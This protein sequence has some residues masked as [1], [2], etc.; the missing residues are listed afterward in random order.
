[1]NKPTILLTTYWPF[2]KIKKFFHGC[3]ETSDS[4]T[5]HTGNSAFTHQVRTAEI[6]SLGH[7][8]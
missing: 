5:S 6:G 4:L 2:K 3:K 8:F 1:M 7:L